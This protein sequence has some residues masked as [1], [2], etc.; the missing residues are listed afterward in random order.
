M[1]YEF[2]GKTSSGD[3]EVAV[4]RK[5]FEDQKK[6]EYQEAKLKKHEETFRARKDVAPELWTSSDTARQFS[7]MIHDRWDIPP[8]KVSDTPLSAAIYQARQKHDTNGAIELVMLKMFFAQDNVKAMKDPNI[9]WRHFISSF[10]SLS[11]RAKLEMPDPEKRA[12]SE[13]RAAKVN[14]FLFELDED[15]DV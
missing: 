1:G 13:E 6:A 3:D 9:M 2:F 7:S 14:A 10:G 15:S 4:E 11:D 5:K 8:W 12:R